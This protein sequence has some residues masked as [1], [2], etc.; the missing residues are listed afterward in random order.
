[1]SALS[2]TAPDS[3]KSTLHWITVR[4]DWGLSESWFSDLRRVYL[5]KITEKLRVDERCCTELMCFRISYVILSNVIVM[6]YYMA[7]SLDW[8][9]S[10]CEWRTCNYLSISADRRR[11]CILSSFECFDRTEAY[12]VSQRLTVERLTKERRVPSDNR[13]ISSVQCHAGICCRW[14][15]WECCANGKFEI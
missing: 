6:R 13:Q 9:S 14:I 4:K 3:T 8:S 15:S 5:F 10:Q 11:C 2:F 12:S 7:G 1:M